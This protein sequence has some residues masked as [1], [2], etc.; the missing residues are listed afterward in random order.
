M[1]DPDEAQRATIERHRAEDRR[2]QRAALIGVAICL[3][4]ALAGLLLVHEL[5]KMSSMQDCV[6]QGR[7]NCAP[8]DGGR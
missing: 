7:S 6:M 2:S 8:L 3:L 1:S 5:H 4:L